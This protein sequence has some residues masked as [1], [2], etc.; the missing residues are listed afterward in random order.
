MIEKG[1]VFSEGIGYLFAFGKYLS[2]FRNRMI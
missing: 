2:S 1:K